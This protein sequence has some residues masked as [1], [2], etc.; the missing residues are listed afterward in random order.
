MVD[1]IYIAND[2]VVFIMMG[3][4]NILFIKT[5]TCEIIHMLMVSIQSLKM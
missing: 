2:L 3:H 5:Q 1:H 4:S